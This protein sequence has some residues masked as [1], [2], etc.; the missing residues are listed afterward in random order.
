MSNAIANIAI[1]G[2]VGLGAR[3]GVRTAVRP[4]MIVP[5]SAL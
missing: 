3:R 2:A 1:F 5:L 4:V